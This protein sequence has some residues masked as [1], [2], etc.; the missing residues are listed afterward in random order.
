MVDEVTLDDVSEQIEALCELLIELAGLEYLER[1]WQPEPGCSVY[2]FQRFGLL[3][4][5]LDKKRQFRDEMLE[6]LRSQCPETDAFLAS[7]E[8]K[9]K[10]EQNQ[11]YN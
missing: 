10:T 8:V 5:M 3:L 7:F 9:L 11:K 1:D 4:S 6:S 2:E